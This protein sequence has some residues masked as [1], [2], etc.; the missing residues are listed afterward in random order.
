MIDQSIEDRANILIGGGTG[1][2]KTTFLNA[3]IG[4][5]ARLRSLMIGSTSSRIPQRSTARRATLSPSLSHRMSRSRA[6]RSAL[7]Y[8]PDRIIF[9][10][11]RYG[12]VALEWLKAS[13]TGHPGG[14]CTIHADG[15]QR[16]LPRMRDLLLEC[17]SGPVP[18]NIIYEAIGLCVYLKDI[19]G[20]GPR[21][22]EV[23]KVQP[24][25]NAGGNFQYTNY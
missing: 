1:T 12:E 14:M 6:V 20:F 24:S 13:S 2:G 11:L 17:F 5:I 19:P 10:E 4:E 16:M 3:L 7:R 21:V 23:A 18:M 22:V 25:L 9:G 8:K 15:A